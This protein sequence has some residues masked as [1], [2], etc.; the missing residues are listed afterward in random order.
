MCSPVNSIFDLIERANNQP[1]GFAQSVLFA[2][3]VQQLT[4]LIAIS[5][6]RT[7]ELYESQ[8]KIYALKSLDSVMS[9]GENN[10][11]NYDL[12][13]LRLKLDEMTLFSKD[14][15][16]FASKSVEFLALATEI[17]ATSETGL[18]PLAHASA[19]PSASDSD[20]DNLLKR[21]NELKSNPPPTNTLE[22]RMNRLGCHS[23]ATSNVINLSAMTN[24]VDTVDDIIAQTTDI[25]QL[26]G[27]IIDQSASR[28]VEDNDDN[29]DA[30]LT[31][32]MLADMISAS[33]SLENPAV[34]QEDEEGIEIAAISKIDI[35]ILE[36]MNVLSQATNIEN[37]C[38]EEGKKL[39]LIREAMNLLS[40]IN[41]LDV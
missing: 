36:T 24:K 31:N 25:I 39:V 19:D 11:N 33:V 17:F 41:I 8:Q 35:K 7:K 38:D 23:T 29:D 40:S 37:D 32:A 2:M 12:L 14:G 21:L 15:D 5:D 9:T 28:V 10:D 3:V 30:V 16:D 13:K 4:P 20:G 18:S 22:D 6:S 26:E 1:S 34:S 27:G